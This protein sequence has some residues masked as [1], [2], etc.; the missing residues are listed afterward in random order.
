[1]WLSPAADNVTR[2]ARREGPLEGVAQGVLADQTRA[3]QG[4]WRPGLGQ[5]DQNIVRRPAGPLG[6]AANVAQLFRLGININDFDLIDDPVSAGEQ[7]AAGV[8]AFSFHAVSRSV[9]A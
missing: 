9:C 1:M 8:C 3:E 2:K 7:T 5:R 4:E 6:L